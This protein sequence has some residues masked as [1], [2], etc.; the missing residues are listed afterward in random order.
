MNYTYTSMRPFREFLVSSRQQNDTIR[1]FCAKKKLPFSLPAPEFVYPGCYIQLYGILRKLKRSDSIVFYSFYQLHQLSSKQLPSF[2][3][4]LIDL[5]VDIHSAS[6][7]ISL[8]PI[9]LNEHLL[10]YLDV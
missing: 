5:N 8:S 2:I 6:E 9:Q 3:S 4:I 7:E 1:D 10:N